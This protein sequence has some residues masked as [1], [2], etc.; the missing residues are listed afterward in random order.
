MLSI[1][2]LWCNSK[3]GHKSVHIQMSNEWLA[4]KNCLRWWI[5][6]LVLAFVFRGFILHSNTAWCG[7]CP[8]GC[9]VGGYILNIYVVLC[10]M[11]LGDKSCARIALGRPNWDKLG[12]KWQGMVAQ[13][14]QRVKPR[15]LWMWISVLVWGKSTFTSVVP[16]KLALKQLAGWIEVYFLSP[17]FLTEDDE[18]VILFFCCW[19]SRHDNV[20]EAFHFHLLKVL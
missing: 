12:V 14:T 1:H 9:G 18:S 8:L 17:S 5:H 19:G 16:F 7:H 3:Q 2:V 13:H 11:V 6:I 10:V 15:P 4:F 20:S